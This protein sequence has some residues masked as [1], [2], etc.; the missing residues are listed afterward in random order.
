MTDRDLVSQQAYNI[1]LLTIWF[2]YVTFN[3]VVRKWLLTDSLTSNV[4]LGVQIVAPLLFAWLAKTRPLS[5]FTSSVLLIYSGMLIAMIF[6][7]LAHTLS[8]GII[9]YCLHVGVFLPLLVY[10]N[11]RDAFPVERMNRLFLMIALIEMV[12]GIVQFLAPADSVINK[13]VRDTTDIGGIAKL[14]AV[15]RVR[16]TGTFSYLGGMTSLFTFFGF[17]IW[18][19]RLLKLSP[20]AIY[21]LLVA[22]FV[23]SPMTGSRGLTALLI[24]L[25]GFGFMSTLADVR[26][27]ITLSVLFGVLLVLAQYNDLSLVGEAYTGLSERVTAHVDDGENESR[28]IGQI[29]EIIEFRGNYPIFGTGLGGTYQGAKALYGESIYLQEY[30]YYEE[31][32]ERIILEGGY[33]LFF[34]RLLLWVL[35]LRQSRIPFFFCLLLIYLH[36]FYAVTV[37]NVFTAFYTVMGILYLDRCYY[38]RERNLV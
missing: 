13:Y 30:G 25:V 12:L 5:R 14:F 22:C 36:V 1:R 24:I 27:S 2:L 31:E 34:V 15:D 9:G 6:N 17:A 7:P 3:G 35:L 37:F 18:G 28:I 11:D 32:P 16:I 21:L 10:L 20:A 19:M 8:H 26:G 29:E 38:L 33:L 4:L 23:I